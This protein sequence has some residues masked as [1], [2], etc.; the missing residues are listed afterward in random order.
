M[1]TC[2][3]EPKGSRTSK[4][5]SGPSGPKRR[6]PVTA[7][8][9][10]ELSALSG[11]SQGFSEQEILRPGDQTGKTQQRGEQQASQ[12]PTF[13]QRKAPGAA[14]ASDTGP[15]QQWPCGSGC[16]GRSCGHSKESPSPSYPLVPSAPRQAR[17]QL[18]SGCLYSPGQ[19]HS[20]PPQP[21]QAKAQMAG[22]GAACGN[23]F[24]PSQVGTIAGRATNRDPKR[25]PGKRAKA[26]PVSRAA[27]LN[28][29]LTP[30]QAWLVNSTA[31]P[32]RLRL[33]GAGKSRGLAGLPFPRPSPG[34][35]AAAAGTHR[36]LPPAPPPG[37]LARPAAD[38]Q[39]K[40]RNSRRSSSPTRHI[41]RSGSARSRR[42]LPGPTGQRSIDSSP[43]APPSAKDTA[44]H[45][46][47]PASA[48]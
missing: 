24:P 7:L 41:S 31:P 11:F 19:S 16:T 3:W 15:R 21:H 20:P 46:C 35:Q 4:L 9:C 34:G 40:I 25:R 33:A 42:A 5:T 29:R 30:G 18:G 38:S 10:A 32:E 13:F 23:R 28:S 45:V 43:L 48:S 1:N 44:R 47:P 22:G 2:V 27:F 39:G 17:L 36:H 12:R 6:G 14:P 37:S 8:Q 26:P